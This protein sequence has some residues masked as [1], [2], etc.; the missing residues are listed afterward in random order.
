MKRIFSSIVYF[1]CDCS[2][3]Q[4]LKLSPPDLLE[5]IK[6]VSLG[7]ID[8][9]SKA[10]YVVSAVCANM[11]ACGTHCR[12]ENTVW[13]PA[14]AEPETWRWGGGQTDVFSA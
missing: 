8:R 9:I 10:L 12:G 5:P 4:D 13:F 14:V 6:R 1:P 7:F 2:V 11:F 3:P